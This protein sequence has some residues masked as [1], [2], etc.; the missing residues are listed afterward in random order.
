MGGWLWF[1]SALS[2]L[3]G[4]RVG[5]GGSSAGSLVDQEIGF[6]DVVHPRG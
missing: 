6:F 3:L 1:G 4:S 5:I 2:A